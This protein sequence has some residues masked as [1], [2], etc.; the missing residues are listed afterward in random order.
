VSVIAA[1]LA[2]DD[3]RA[4]RN[5]IIL[6]LGQ[7]FYSSATVIMFTTAGLIG[8]QI[9]PSKGWATLPISAFVVGTALSTVP[10]SLLMR[11]IGRKPGFILGAFAGLLG[12]LLGMYAIYRRDF[13]LFVMGT[14]LQGVFQAFILHSRFAAADMASPAFRPKAISWVMTGGV[15]AAIF[16]TLLVIGT[17]DLLAPVTFAGCYA[18]MAVLCACAIAVLGFLDIPH[19]RTEV[20]RGSGRPLSEILRQPRFLVAVVAAT[21]S[22]GMM[23]L[24]MTASP[25]AM[26]DCGFGYAEASWAIQWH[27]LA[28]F[29]PSF[30]TGHVIARFGA[31]RICAAGLV[32]LG[33]A[34]MVAITGIRFENF[35]L[36]LV[37][38]GLGWNLGFIGGTTLLTQCYEPAEAAKVQAFNDFAVFATVACAS[39]LSGQLLAWFGWLSVNIA[40]FP[41]VLT[42]LALFGWLALQRQRRGAF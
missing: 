16:G 34:A 6:A 17:T 10:A 9:A 15:A 1:E 41:L 42:A 21:V 31:E 7:A 38:L 30:F 24:V 2:H 22:Y 33:L 39:L 12:A 5:A 40:V 19:A 3:S 25:I 29:V 27:V 18:A 13:A 4:R 8:V 11:Q 35:A 14:V 28:M 26:S 36:G 32:L 20:A 37:L 23:N